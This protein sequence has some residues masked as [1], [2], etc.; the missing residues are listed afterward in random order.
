MIRFPEVI[1][2]LRW[3]SEGGV[4]RYQKGVSEYQKPII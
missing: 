4:Y 3:E 2:R 1:M